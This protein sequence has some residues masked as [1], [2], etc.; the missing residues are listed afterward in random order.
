MHTTSRLTARRRGLLRLQSRNT[1]TRN[2]HVGTAALGCPEERSSAGSQIPQMIS[3]R[4]SQKSNARLGLESRSTWRA[5]LART[6]EGGCPHIADGE[7][8][9]RFWRKPRRCILE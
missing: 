7:V 3:T 1:E 8:P 4:L 2:N 5:V 9:G 6:A